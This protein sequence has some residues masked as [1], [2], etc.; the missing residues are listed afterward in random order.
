M[1]LE[2]FFLIYVMCVRKEFWGGEGGGWARNF[3]FLVLSID[4]RDVNSRFVKIFQ[5]DGPMLIPYI[6][7]HQAW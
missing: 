2:Y 1:I 6:R 4:L 7:I 3:Y 5:P